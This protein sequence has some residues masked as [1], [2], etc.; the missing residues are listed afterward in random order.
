LI[1][2]AEDALA[3]CLGVPVRSKNQL[4]EIS[5]TE[6]DEKRLIRRTVVGALD[7]HTVELSEDE[8]VALARPKPPNLEA[9]IRSDV[10]SRRA[11]SRMELG[12]EHRRQYAQPKA[13]SDRRAHNLSLIQHARIVASIAGP[14]R[15]ENA[16][17]AANGTATPHFEENARIR[18]DDS[19]YRSPAECMPD[20]KARNRNPASSRQA[21][22]NSPFEIL[23]IVR[24]P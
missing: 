10:L 24:L 11:A 14:A 3:E 18:R 5:R 16:G 20:R 2:K 15:S 7:G 22:M 6:S 21:M 12:S 19:A 8:V 4:L 23:S 13:T 1:E 9:S 17:R